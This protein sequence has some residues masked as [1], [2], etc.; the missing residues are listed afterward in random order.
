M[1]VTAAAYDERGV[2]FSAAC[3]EAVAGEDGVLRVSELW[4]PLDRQNGKVKLF[5]L[6]KGA[7]SPLRGT[8]ER[9]TALAS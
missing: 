9:E 1:T 2:L 5:F 6:E 7:L 4:L 8:L 3:G